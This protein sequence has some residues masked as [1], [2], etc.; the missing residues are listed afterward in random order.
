M[1]PFALVRSHIP[2]A[3]ACVAILAEVIALAITGAFRE[4]RSPDWPVAL[5]LCV[6]G[7]LIAAATLA[8]DSRWFRDG[9]WGNRL[10][11]SALIL[12]VVWLIAQLPPAGTD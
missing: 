4:P 10:S 9:V 8:A 2:I 1:K 6:G 3:F 5:G 12:A 7:A 11:Y